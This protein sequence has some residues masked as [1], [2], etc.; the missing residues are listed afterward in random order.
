MN[1]ALE[2]LISLMTEMDKEGQVMIDYSAIRKGVS[3]K[4]QV[5]F[6]KE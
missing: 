5:E 2:T 3:T 4:I 1:K 6:W